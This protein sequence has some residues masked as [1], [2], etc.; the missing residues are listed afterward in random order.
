MPTFGLAPVFERLWASRVA[1]VAAVVLGLALLGMA[2]YPIGTRLFLGFLPPLVA[3]ALLIV[4]AFHK[5]KRLPNAVR[6]LGIWLAAFWLVVQVLVEVDLHRQL[7]PEV[8]VWGAIDE[9][10]CAFSYGEAIF[11]LNPRGTHL[12]AEWRPTPVAPQDRAARGWVGARCPPSESW[13]HVVEEL[14]NSPGHFYRVLSDRVVIVS[15]DR[16]IAA[17]LYSD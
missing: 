4:F 5:R 10:R 9:S 14:S 2:V 12:T 3:L 15:P 16:A 11:R 8:S 13:R 1:T 7:T 17:A 6:A